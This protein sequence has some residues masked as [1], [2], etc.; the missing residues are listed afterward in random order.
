MNGDEPIRK[1]GGKI[2]YGTE[3]EKNYI[4]SLGTFALESKRGREAPEERRFRLLLGYRKS[5]F[6][7]KVWDGID[8]GEILIYIDRKIMNEKIFIEMYGK[9]PKLDG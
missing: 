9:V 6:E 7:R 2:N 8:P 3:S 4:D 1:R 5:I